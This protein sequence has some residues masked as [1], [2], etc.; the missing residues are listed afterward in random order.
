MNYNHFIH[1]CPNLERIKLAFSRSRHEYTNVFVAPQMLKES[2]L[3]NIYNYTVNI[4]IVLA[5]FK[6]SLPLIFKLS[7]INVVSLSVYDTVES[8]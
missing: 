7:I 4:I 2:H 1:V 8:L 5:I 6:N 3:A